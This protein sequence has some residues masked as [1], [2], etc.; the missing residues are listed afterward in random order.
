MT[1][2][3]AKV[4]PN[5]VFMLADTRVYDPR[6]TKS[7]TA[8][9]LKTTTLAPKV[10]LAFTGDVHLAECAVH[11]FRNSYGTSAPFKAT[12]NHFTKATVNNENEY[13][14]GFAGPR[15]LFICLKG[16]T[17]KGA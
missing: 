13:L 12:L 2:V 7:V 8:G 6:A 3:V 17:A 15:R 1:L 10:A 11:D 9:M 4:T 5:Q 14:L 16:S